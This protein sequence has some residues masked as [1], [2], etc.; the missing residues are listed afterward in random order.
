MDSKR[1]SSFINK[2]VKPSKT[3]QSESSQ[4]H[5]YTESCTFTREKVG[6]TEIARQTIDNR[7]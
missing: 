7:A 4:L 3:I 6:V 1:Q 2:P 5:N